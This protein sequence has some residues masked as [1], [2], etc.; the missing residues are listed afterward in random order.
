MWFK[1]KL[2]PTRKNRLSFEKVKP[3]PASSSVSQIFL[4]SSASVSSAEAQVQHKF[5]LHRTV[6]GRLLWETWIMKVD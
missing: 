5:F 1:R 3:L 2:N 4:I 6:I